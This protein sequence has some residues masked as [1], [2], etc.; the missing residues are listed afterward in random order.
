MENP[1]DI[2][3]KLTHLR[4]YVPFLER[5]I[6]KLEV[7]SQQMCS[8]KGQLERLHGLHNFLTKPLPKVNPRPGRH[9]QQQQQQQQH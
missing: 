6:L 1:K 5:M 2:Q 7:R 9:Q 8:S 3:D 4:S